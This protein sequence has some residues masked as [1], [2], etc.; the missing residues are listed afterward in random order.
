MN[1]NRHQPRRRAYILLFALMT[2]FIVLLFVTLMA[3]FT[4]TELDRGR[5]TLLESEALQVLASAKAWST[6]RAGELRVGESVA[7]PTGTLLPPPATAS[8]TLH[9]SQA[10]DG[11]VLVECS[12]RVER[13]RTHVTRRATWLVD[14]PAM[15]GL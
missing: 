3:G 7:V 6:V 5:R 15:H 14:A 13:S 10:P 8:A 1:R 4:Q 11:R 2:T 9:A 12:V